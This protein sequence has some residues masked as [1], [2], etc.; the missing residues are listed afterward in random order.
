MSAVP[1]TASRVCPPNSI[2][3]LKGW[4]PQLPSTSPPPPVPPT[5]LPA[6]SFPFFF[7]SLKL[8]KTEIKRKKYYLFFLRVNPLIIFTF[9]YS[10][11]FIKKLP[12]NFLK[13]PLLSFFFFFFLSLRVSLFTVSLFFA[14]SP[15]IPGSPGL[16][17]MGT[18]LGTLWRGDSASAPALHRDT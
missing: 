17:E 3:T 9:I 5:Q 10:C 2:I 11:C 16:G 13:K 12:L 14:L 1:T 7:H 6:A 18:P 15:L 4:E 8:K